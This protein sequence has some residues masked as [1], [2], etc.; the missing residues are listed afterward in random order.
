VSRSLRDSRGHHRNDL[1]R[2]LQAPVVLEQNDVAGSQ[3][4]VRRERHG[5]VDDTLGCLLAATAMAVVLIYS[6]AR[7]AGLL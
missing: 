4:S 3:T 7:L 5:D 6:D 2:G 1:L